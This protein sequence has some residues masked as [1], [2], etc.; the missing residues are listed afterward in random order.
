VTWRAGFVC[1]SLLV[2]RSR[3]PPAT[4]YQLAALVAA[5]AVP[6]VASKYGAGP[7]ISGCLLVLPL[8]AAYP[9]MQAGAY[10]L[11]TT[12]FVCPLCPLVPVLGVALNVYLAVD[13]SWYA[14]LRLGLLWLVLL[15]LYCLPVLRPGERSIEAVRRRKGSLGRSLLD[16]EPEG[17]GQ[18]PSAALEATPQL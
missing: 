14:W 9:L 10:D 7:I 8:G 13:L 18:R 16:D 3:D 1:A 12:A 5:M 2:L 6:S 11:P 17:Q 4:A 15:L